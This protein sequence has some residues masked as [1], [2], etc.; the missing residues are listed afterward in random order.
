MCRV[1]HAMRHFVQYHK[2]ADMGTYKPPDSG[3]IVL[4]NK[5]SEPRQGDRV[6]LVMGKGSPCRYS[7]C[8]SFVVDSVQ[9]RATG[10][11]R[12]QV[13]GS[14]GKHFT[15]FIPLNDMSWLP[16]LKRECGNFGFGPHH[17]KN[18]ALINA[19]EHAALP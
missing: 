14:T 6:S 13:L 1:A 3:F 18:H 5:R 8:C 10:R 2:A 7:L 9:R 12:K 4:T 11:F 15:P 19:L 17:I 16:D